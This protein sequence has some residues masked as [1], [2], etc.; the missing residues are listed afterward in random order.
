MSSPSRNSGDSGSFDDVGPQSSPAA[1]NDAP[2]PFTVDRTDNLSPEVEARPLSGI[3]RPLLAVERPLSQEGR[4][5]FEEKRRLAVVYQPLPLTMGDLSAVERPLWAVEPFAY[6][7]EPFASGVDH[8][9]PGMEVNSYSREGERL[10]SHV[11]LPVS[12]VDHRLPQFELSISTIERSSSV[13][14]RHSTDDVNS[15]GQ[16]HTVANVSQ[17]SRLM[18]LWHRIRR[19][20]TCLNLYQGGTVVF[21]GSIIWAALVKMY[22]CVYHFY[23]LSRMSKK[24]R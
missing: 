13:V 23:R 22:Y 1:G 6:A 24:Q 14:E 8:P 21:M 7:V 10:I 12:V 16:H 5:L 3:E 19:R 20:I 15:H 2:T 18:R 9:L 4:P 17:R 11:E